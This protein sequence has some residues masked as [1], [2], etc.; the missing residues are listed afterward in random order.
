MA[1]WA[2]EAPRSGSAGPSF[3][4]LDRIQARRS[5][6]LASGASFVHH[7]RRPGA[8]VEQTRLGTELTPYPVSR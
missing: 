1:T 2:G 6:K 3:V 4:D 8:E 5:T 7:G